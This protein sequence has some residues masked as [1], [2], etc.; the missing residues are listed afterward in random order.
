MNSRERLSWEMVIYSYRPQ[1]RS[2]LLLLSVYRD[3]SMNNLVS[4]FLGLC[5]AYWAWR[6]IRMK[7]NEQNDSFLVSNGHYYKDTAN[8]EKAT[9]SL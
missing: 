5:S 4:N 9:I 6:L 7:Y 1:Y 2:F 3:S 8:K